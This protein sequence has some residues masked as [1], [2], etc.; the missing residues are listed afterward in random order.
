MP[1]VVLFQRRRRVRLRQ[2]LS[3]QLQAETFASVRRADSD[4]GLS[5]CVKTKSWGELRAEDREELLVIHSFPDFPV[6]G[7]DERLAP[8]PQTARGGGFTRAP[9]QQT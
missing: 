6:L 4:D 3:L 2:R 5:P 8:A 1:C 7:S 9:P